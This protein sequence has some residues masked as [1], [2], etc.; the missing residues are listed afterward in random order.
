M[1]RS[2]SGSNASSVHTSYTMQSGMSSS[3]GS[4]LAFGNI[5][6]QGG[7]SNLSEYA[8]PTMD[9]AEAGRGFE[10]LL[11][12]LQSTSADPRSVRKAACCAALVETARERRSGNANNDEESEVSPNEMFVAIIAALTSLQSSLE[13]KQK[14]LSTGADADADGVES[15]SINTI[16]SELENTA[17]PLL[18]ILRRILPYVAHYSNN[19]GALLSHQF[20]T[21]SRML[22]MFVALGYALPGVVSGAADGRK[23]KGKQQQQQQQGTGANALLRQLLKVSTTLLLVAPPSM[24]SSTKEKELARLLHS[25]IVPMFH[26]VRPKVRK[27]A[28]GCGMEIVVVACASASSSFN[29]VSDMSDDGKQNDIVK[30]VQNQRKTIADFLWEYCHAITSNYSPGSKETSS[31]LIHVLRFL[32]SALPFADDVRIR[33]RFGE[34]CLKLMN[35]GDAAAEGGGKKNKSKGEVSMEVIKET[36]LTLL[37]CLEMTE[38]EQQELE[39][40]IVGTTTATASEEMPKFAARSLAFLL[41]HRPNSANSSYNGDA[42]VVYGRCLLACMERMLGKDNSIVGQDDNVP[43]SKLLAMKLL[44]NVLTSMLHLCDAPAAE[45]DGNDTHSETCGSEF[46][47][48]VSRMIPIV[49]SYLDGNTTN[50]KLHRVALEILPQCISIVQQSLQIQY[51]SAWGSILSGGYAT[52]TSTLANC[53][54]QKKQ[55]S[56]A[57]GEDDSELE[58]KLLSWVKTCVLSLLRLH[59]DVTKDGVARTAVEY[60][61]STIIRGM[62]V[63]LFLTVVEFVDEDDSSG[64]KN[65]S[66]STGGGIR[67]DRAWLL[68]LMKQSAATTTSSSTAAGVTSKTHLAF[69]QGH[70]LSLARK[71]DA[72]SADGHRTAAEIS[73]QKSRVVE[74]WSL[75]PAFFCV[76]PLDMKENFGMVAKT[77]VKALGDHERYPKLIPIICG[78]LKNLAIGVM[79]RAASKSSPNATED[80]DVLSNV[81]T[82]I[83]PSLFKLVETLNQSPSKKSEG[84]D[85]AMMEVDSV[86]SSKKK[87][88][89]AE[90]KSQQNHMQLVEAVTDAIGQ[91]AQICPREFLQN[92]FKKVVQRLLVATT[93]IAEDSSDDK[94]AKNATAM[95]MSSLLGLGQALVASGSL[96]DASLSLLYRAVR[97]LVRSDEHDPRVQKRA[98]K[99]LAEI[100]DKHKE[101]VTSSERLTEMTELMVDSIVTCQVS[102][103][104]MRLK[105]MTHIV[106]GFDSEN[107]VHMEV[108]PKIMG[109]VLLCL[110]DS[111]AKTREASYQLLLAMG[112]ARDDM[113]DYFRIILAALGAQTTHMR[114]AAVMALSRLTFEY[115]RDDFTVQS[116][117]PSLMQTVAVL[118]DDSSREVTKSVIGFVR[119]SVAAM[120]REQLEPLLPEVVGG[121]MKYN[122]GKDRFRAKI[123]IILKKLVRV[124]GYEVI[125]PLVPEEHA[126]LIT[127]MR[128]L[129]ERAARRKAAGVQDGRS[130]VHND[131]DD[132]MESDEDDSD[133]GRTFMTGATGFTRMTAMS[134]KITKSSAMDR[135]AKSKSVVSGAR[136]TMTSKSAKASGPRI[137]ADL[138]GEILDMLDASKM[139]RSVRFADMDMNDGDFSDDDDDDDMQFDNDGRIVISDGMPEPKGKKHVTEHYQSD[140]DENLDLK[141]GG[142]RRRVSKFESVKLANKDAVR[143]KQKAKK[144]S[145]VSLGSAYKSKKAGG[146]VRKKGQKYEP[147]AYVPLNAKDYTKKNRDQAVSK[148]GTVVRSTKR[149]R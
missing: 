25:T 48:F 147:Y 53:L 65:L 9:P 120:T 75:F 70:V 46:N 76:Y 58:S 130:V 34:G 59:D 10:K 52:F 8:I 140:D 1:G 35:G 127:H 90:T 20:G 5:S 61:T 142:K 100:C 15:S 30:K 71:C 44:P 43:A 104:H 135:S 114:S 50:A 28:W 146:D 42:N 12:D 133:D 141:S 145:T 126:R 95:R 106:K 82:K 138:N 19:S 111:N 84:D 89:A 123:K 148:M 103:R 134:G 113:T 26:D 97:P 4:S 73:I 36:L 45:G 115:A 131:F 29:N 96:D 31:K 112:T 7:S 51:R 99:V 108:I 54:L 81:S 105:C 41:Q 74:L 129:S 32:S 124:Y 49:V 136:S 128:K 86:S 6:L 11:Q 107:Q 83:L 56:A 62:G 39:D 37:S 66:S 22:R 68:P 21:L 109:E 18:E 33:I 2:R 72:A 132:M 55:S 17:L 57:G 125:A 139:A 98:Y 13:Q 117:L 119:V 69:F 144:E 40:S 110:K 149:K 93:E 116:L 27:A 79:E 94:D 60:A 78:G 80:Y 101:F 64:K 16:T 121:L 143:K 3:M 77:V 85:E 87:K 38:Q 47:Q 14:S 63:E 24:S 23:K 118:F 102:A 67:D 91:L 137:K 122:K 92:L 88:K